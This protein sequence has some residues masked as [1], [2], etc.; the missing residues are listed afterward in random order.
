MVTYSTGK[1]PA[2]GIVYGRDDVDIA[3]VG[4]RKET[5]DV[6]SPLIK[7]RGTLYLDTDL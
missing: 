4:L 6:E 1:R 5:G 2:F 3:V 7:E